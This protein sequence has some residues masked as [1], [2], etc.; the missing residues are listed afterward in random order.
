MQFDFSSLSLSLSFQKYGRVSTLPFI[1]LIHAPTMMSYK[2][3]QSFSFVREIFLFTTNWSS[4]ELLFSIDLF[5]VV[6]VIYLYSVVLS[7]HVTFVDYRSVCTHNW[8]IGEVIC[9]L[10]DKRER[11]R[12]REREN[13]QCRII[14]PSINEQVD[15]F[16]TFSVWF[17]N[18]RCQKRQTMFIL[19][20]MSIP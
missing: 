10:K 3:L 2:N 19:S 16:R 13:L 14:S 1:F 17:S 18:S 8:W 7:I 20:R 11:E 15:L 4:L 6:E 12:E 5:V 9:N